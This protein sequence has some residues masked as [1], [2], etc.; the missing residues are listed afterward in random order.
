MNEE[1]R[2]KLDCAKKHLAMAKQRIAGL[3]F[4]VNN[5]LVT[6]EVDWKNNWSDIYQ[7]LFLDLMS[8]D[9]L[10]EHASDTMLDSKA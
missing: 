1:R 5:F 2:E 6:D 3:E 8:A 9:K 4:L 7:L 10:I